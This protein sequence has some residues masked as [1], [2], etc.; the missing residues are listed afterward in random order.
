MVPQLSESNRNLVMG[1]RW[2]PNTKRDWPTDRRSHHNFDFGF[3]FEL[4]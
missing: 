4:R 2:V 3:Q 1:P